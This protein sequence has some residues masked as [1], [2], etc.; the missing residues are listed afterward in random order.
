MEFTTL[1]EVYIYRDNKGWIDSYGEVIEID[2]DYS[3]K[4]IWLNALDYLIELNTTLP[5]TLQF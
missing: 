2:D 1:N 5:R 4:E 3:T